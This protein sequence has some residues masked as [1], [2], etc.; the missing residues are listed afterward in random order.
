[1]MDIHGKIHCYRSFCGL[2]TLFD[3]YIS[4]CRVWNVA[5]TTAELE[6]GICYVDP[7]SEGLISY[8]RF[9]GET[10]EDGTVLDMTGHGH[11]AKPYGDITYVDNQNARSKIR[12]N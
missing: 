1:M 3:G 10:Q 6:D 7:T 2:C 9:D 5:R 11:N 8:W 12:D 4:E